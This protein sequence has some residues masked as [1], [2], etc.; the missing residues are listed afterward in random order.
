MNTIALDVLQK[1]KD[2][3]LVLDGYWISNARPD[4]RE[5]DKTNSIGPKLIHPG[6]EVLLGMV[7]MYWTILVV[8]SSSADCLSKS[9]AI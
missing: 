9:K 1:H 5:T 6:K 8:A 3:I 2:N 4:S 7:R